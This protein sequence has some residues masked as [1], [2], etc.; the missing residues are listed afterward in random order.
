MER[1]VGHVIGIIA[2]AGITR[3][4]LHL[5]QFADKIDSHIQRVDKQGCQR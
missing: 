3:H 1:G 4:L 2:G 5:A